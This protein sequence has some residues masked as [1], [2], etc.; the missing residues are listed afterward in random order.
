LARLEKE[1]TELV[2]Q[3]IQLNERLRKLKEVHA[4]EYSKALT[5][6]NSEIEARGLVLDKKRGE[7]SESREIIQRLKSELEEKDREIHFL[8]ESSQLSKGALEK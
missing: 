8:K 2:K 6:L 1:R 3:V 5:Q 7:L 4:E